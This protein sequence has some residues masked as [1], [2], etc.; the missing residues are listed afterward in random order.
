M[1]ELKRLDNPQIKWL[2]KPIANFGVVGVISRTPRL[3]E[4]EKRIYEIEERVDARQEERTGIKND[5]RHP[6][7]IPDDPARIQIPDFA[8][9]TASDRQIAFVDSDPPGRKALLCHLASRQD[10]NRVG[11]MCPCHQ[12]RVR[13][14]NFYIN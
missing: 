12:L 10:S 6:A 7:P 1:D 13:F 14:T 3:M 4:D 11:T 2:G 8:L 5:V 9:R